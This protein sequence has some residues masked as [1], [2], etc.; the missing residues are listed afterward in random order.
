MNEILPAFME[1]TI[2]SETKRYFGKA[3][4]G[5]LLGRMGPTTG[6][7][8]GWMGALKLDGST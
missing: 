4:F 2:E 3:V 8:S 6:E 7:H 5:E 1:I